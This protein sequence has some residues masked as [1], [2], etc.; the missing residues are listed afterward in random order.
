[1][2]STSLPSKFYLGKPSLDRS[3]MNPIRKT[4]KGWWWGGRGPFKT[5][6]KAVEVARAAY[7][8]GYRGNPADGGSSGGSLYEDFHGVPPARV[9][10]M[11]LPVPKKGARLIKI[12]RLLE[13]TYLPEEPSQRVGTA[14][15]HEFGDTG[16]VVLPDKPILAT[17]GEHFYIIP[18]KSKAYFEERG[19]VG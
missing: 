2:K 13:L 8:T 9:R 3:R 11:R 14:F 18:D 5:R 15:R 10:K 7:S 6:K 19:I 12:G 1:M 17:D 4:R 16:S